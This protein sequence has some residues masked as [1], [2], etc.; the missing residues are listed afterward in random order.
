[1]GRRVDLLRSLPK[2]TRDLAGRRA[3]K[4]P[5]VVAVARQYGRD[6]FDG[7]RRHGYGGYHYDGRWR[8]VARQMLDYYFFMIDGRWPP[9]VLDVGAAKGFLVS[10]LVR[11]G[12]DAYGIDVSRYAVVEAPHGEAVGRLHLGTAASLPFPDG[13]FDLVVSINTLHNLTRP[14][15]V[16]ALGEI[17]RVG[18][19]VAYVVVDAWETEEERRRAEDWIVT[20]QFYTSVDGW[21]ELFAE[22]GYEGDYSFTKV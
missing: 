3:D 20:A 6:Y 12:A 4:S 21:L 13:S 15:V 1:M 7:D 17:T 10:D 19:G 11:A 18:R 14:D 2:V 5:E 22:A 8:P 16:T 9:R